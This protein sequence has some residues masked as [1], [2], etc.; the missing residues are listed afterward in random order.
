MLHPYNVCNACFVQRVKQTLLRHHFHIKLLKQ[1]TIQLHVCL[2]FG[3]LVHDLQLIAADDYT[4]S[5]HKIIY[6]AYL[7]MGQNYILCVSRRTL[8]NS[9]SAINPMQHL[10]ST[11]FCLA[12]M[13]LC[14]VHSALCNSA[15]YYLCCYLIIVVEFL[16]CLIC[17]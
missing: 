15:K 16:P 12:T 14:T 2:D 13:R 6:L 4:Y 17:I 9:S 5:R 11:Y 1:L 7:F 3:R 8:K 10:D